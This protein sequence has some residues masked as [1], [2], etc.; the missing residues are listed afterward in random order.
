MKVH[1]YL[2]IWA[3]RNGLFERNNYRRA[4]RQRLR[5]IA[6]R[7]QQELDDDRRAEPDNAGASNS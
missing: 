2:G 4:L 1:L 5:E 3:F 7:V 6:S